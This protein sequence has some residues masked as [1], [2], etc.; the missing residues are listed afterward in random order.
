MA[1]TGAIQGAVVPVTDLQ[2]QDLSSLRNQGYISDQTYLGGQGVTFLKPWSATA[3]PQLPTGPGSQGTSTLTST[4]N[5]AGV[6]SSAFPVEQNLVNQYNSLDAAKAADIAA[7]TAKFNE[8][9]QQV[10]R[11][12][13][14]SYGARMVNAG[15]S[16]GTGNT[17]GADTTV[18]N[19]L[20]LEKEATNRSLKELKTAQVA[21]ENAIKKGYSD[22]G[23]KLLDAI[24]TARMN[25]FTK[26]IQ[27]MNQET[28]QKSQRLQELQFNSQ[29]Q[30]SQITNDIAI[31]NAIRQIPQGQSVTIGGRVYQGLD[32]SAADSFFKGSDVVNLMKSIPQGQTQTITNPITNATYTI[33]GLGTDNEKN[34]IF[35]SVDDK[36]NTTF[37]TLNNSGQIVKMV[38]AGNIEKAKEQEALIGNLTKDERQ[39]LNQ[40]QDNARQTSQIKVFNDVRGAYE[41]GRAAA[42]NP[43][44]GIGDLVLLRTLAKITDPNSSVREEE[45]ATFQTAQGALPRYGIQFTTGMFKGDQLTAEARKNFT[46]MLEDIYKQREAAYS[47]AVG[48]YQN[49][50]AGTN[51]DP[52]LAIPYYLAPPDGASIT[53]TPVNLSSLP[54]L[55]KSYNS[56]A[57]LEK[58]Y[59][60]YEDYFYQQAKQGK[61]ETKILRE[62]EQRGSGG[63]SMSIQLGSRLAQVNNNPGNLRFANQAGAKQGQGG[64]ASFPTPQAGYQALVDQIA[65]DTSRGHTLSSFINKFAPSSEN[66][67][68]QYVQQIAAT[69]GINPN[70][71]LNKIDKNKL[72]R[73]MAL[74]ESLSKIA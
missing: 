54:Q 71:P 58:D 14:S 27:L 49:Q 69:L 70:T 36:G 46:Q 13:A 55:N 19:I 23:L 6:A 21:A 52:S 20:S 44:H 33:T 66:N 67:T 39:Y 11:Q 18:G 4:M 7:N 10:E 29:Q 56:K 65:L 37:T 22:Q 74:K 42:N 12:G 1:I 28:Q 61:D 63:L 16:G 9:G 30:N 35:K 51:I 68:R 25:Q 48:F 73:A 72:A 15:Q 17:L 34:Q 41:Q 57:A 45:F 32:V 31:A 62:I 8:A 2:E 43:N 64:F 24:E 26:Q 47:N 40:I 5:A 60:A 3:S 50:L 38:N 53:G 59:P